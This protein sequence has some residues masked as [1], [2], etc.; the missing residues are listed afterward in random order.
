[1]F[2]VLDLKS[3]KTERK[4]DLLNKEI[5]E[6]IKEFNDPNLLKTIQVVIEY[7]PSALME[8]MMRKVKTN[9]RCKCQ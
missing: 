5:S 8:K 4:L 9:N 2:Q 7:S 1:M 6:I 3:N